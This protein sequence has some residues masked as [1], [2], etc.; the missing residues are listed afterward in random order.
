M[1]ATVDGLVSIQ[2]IKT[3]DRK[4]DVRRRW[5]PPASWAAGVASHADEESARPASGSVRREKEGRRWPQ[6]P[7]WRRRAPPSP[8]STTVL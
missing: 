1:A 4:G 3:P 8:L 6:V 2:K 5:W 7:V